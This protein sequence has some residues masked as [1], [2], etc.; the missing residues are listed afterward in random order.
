MQKKNA[1]FI[2]R[3]KFNGHINFEISNSI[4]KIPLLFHIYKK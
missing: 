2:V 3:N 4:I 1:N